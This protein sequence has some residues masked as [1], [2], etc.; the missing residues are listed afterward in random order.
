MTR[1]VVTRFV[2]PYVAPALGVAHKLEDGAKRLVDAVVADSFET[3]VFYASAPKAL[4]GALLDQARIVEDSAD[5]TIQ[6]HAYDA[7][8]RFIPAEAP[9]P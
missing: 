1:T 7:I 4:T 5:T 6:D 2:M 3:G 9:T 8:H